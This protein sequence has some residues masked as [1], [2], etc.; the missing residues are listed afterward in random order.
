MYDQ[1]EPLFSSSATEGIS[2]LAI[3]SLG[4]RSAAILVNVESTNAAKHNRTYHPQRRFSEISQRQ[5]ASHVGSQE[6]A[7]NQT[8]QQAVG[9]V[10][11]LNMMRACK[12]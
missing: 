1:S 7:A 12:G 8:R 5:M 10:I 4:H 9:N 3:V 2:G 6:D 11:R